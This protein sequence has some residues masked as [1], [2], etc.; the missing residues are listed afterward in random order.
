MNILQAQSTEAASRSEQLTLRC[1]RMTKNY[2]VVMLL[3]FPLFSGISGYNYLHAKK[4][5]FFA[6]LSCFWLLYL[7]IQSVR[8]KSCG[9]LIK[10]M[11]ASTLCLLFF[12]L[13]AV[14]SAVLAGG[15]YIFGERYDGLVTHILYAGVVLG[16]CRY[17]KPDITLFYAFEAGYAVCCL[18]AL[19][20]LLGWNALWLYPYG[21]TYYD[22][23][24]Q[25]VGTFLGTV[26]NVDVL[27]AYHCLAIPILGYMSIHLKGKRRI[28]C[29]GSLLLGLTCMIWAGVTSGILA[30]ALTA[31]LFLPSIYT[32]RQGRGKRAIYLIILLVFAAG[33]AALYFIPFHSGVAYELHS[34]LHGNIMDEFG[35]HRIKIWRKTWEVFQQHPLFGVGPENLV[36]YLQIE[37]ERYSDLLGE[38][39]YSQADN[40]HNEY[41][42]LLATFGICGFLPVATLVGFALRKGL[43]YRGKNLAISALTPSLVCYLIQAFFNIG[44]CII[45]PLAC[46][47]VGLVFNQLAGESVRKGAPE[48]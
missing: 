18:M 39:L 25:E 45:T 9:G 27:S 44:L 34:I 12:I 36:Y 16:V 26:G 46:I 29:T 1:Q 21:M 17:G 5:L 13:A 19:L 2:L 22:P 3:F 6:L 20:Q 32:G 31:A 47:E 38:T 37:F 10:D 42:Q 14:I 24:V 7:A 4:F 40:A 30:I 28:L 11:P 35:S 8:C 43:L 48:Q 23:Y 41:L 15:A 33:A